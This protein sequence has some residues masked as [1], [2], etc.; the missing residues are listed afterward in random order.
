[1]S[2]LTSFFLILYCR[3]FQV[4]N[5]RVF[6][7]ALLVLICGFAD[8]KA[9]EL[10]SAIA[11]VRAQCLPIIDDLNHMKTMAGINTAVTGVGTVAGGVA[12]GTGIAKANMDKDANDIDDLITALEQGGAQQ[13]SDLDTFYK[14]FASALSETGTI[15]GEQ[16][17]QQLRNKK[18][19]LDKQSKKLGNWR[20]GMM[21]ANTATNIAG[22]IIAGN[23]RIDDSLQDKINLCMRAVDDLTDVYMQAKISGTETQND[24]LRAEKIVRECGAWSV[25]DVS[26][27][28]KR[29]VGATVSSGIGAGLGLVGTITSATANSNTEFKKQNTEKNLNTVSNV[30]AGGTTVASGAAVIF[31]ATQIAA[32][33]NASRIADKCQEALK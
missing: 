12:L 24:I 8:A 10:S 21:A 9:A 2:I 30:M 22:A 23:N 18:T 27:I 19:D 32:I 15:T 33:K 31:N 1:M 4:N 14:T 6:A 13:V 7:V 25:V 28:D 16:F 29:A 11:N 26:S 3:T 5:M 17:A 20:T